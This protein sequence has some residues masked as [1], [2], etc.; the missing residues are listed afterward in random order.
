MLQYYLLTSSSN[1][2]MAQEYLGRNLAAPCS[3]KNGSGRMVLGQKVVDLRA[4]RKQTFVYY[5]MLLFISFFLM[6]GTQIL[7]FLTTTKAR[8]GIHFLWGCLIGRSPLPPMG[9]EA[10]GTLSHQDKHLRFNS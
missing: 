8:S 9:G 6:L 5:L 1:M 10:C 3:G 7:H 4:R 2:W